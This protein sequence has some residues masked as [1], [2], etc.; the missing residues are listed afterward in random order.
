MK[1]QARLA[2]LNRN[3]SENRKSW[4]PHWPMVRFREKMTRAVPVVLPPAESNATQ[5]AR[6]PD[7]VAEIERLRSR[8]AEMESEQ[9]EARKKRSRSLLVP[10]PRSGWWARFAALGRFTRRSCGA[11]QRSDHGDIDQSREHVG[12][13]FEQIQSVGLT[14]LP[15]EALHIE[16]GCE[17]SPRTRCFVDAVGEW[18]RVQCLQ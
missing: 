18:S 12:S 14:C 10:S 16:Q 9:E 5:P 2:R 4:T 1:S 6:V 13:E 11:R 3:R 15:H 17:G 7:L 8:V